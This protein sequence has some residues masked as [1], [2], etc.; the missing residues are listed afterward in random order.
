[1]QTCGCPV[2]AYA[3]GET[4]ET[5]IDDVTNVFFKDVTADFIEKRFDVFKKER[6]L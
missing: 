1:V 2:I 6:P 3:A 5:V 4:L